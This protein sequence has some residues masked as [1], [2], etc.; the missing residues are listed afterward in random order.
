MYCDLTARHSVRTKEA[1]E[2]GIATLHIQQMCA[3][4]VD[5]GMM[6]EATCHNREKNGTTAFRQTVTARQTHAC[7]LLAVDAGQQG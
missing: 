5:F 3:R 4:G 1:G 2:L 6:H 7:D